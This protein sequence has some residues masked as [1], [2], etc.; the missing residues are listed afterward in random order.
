M[1]LLAN[2]KLRRKLF[3]A[4]VPVAAMVIF[5]GIYASVESEEIDT[6]YSRLIDHE[7]KAVD[8]VNEARS[9]NMRF[10]LYLYRLIV[11]TNPEAMQAINQGLDNTHDEYK[12]RMADAARLSPIFENQIGTASAHFDKMA[13]HAIPVREAALKNMNEKAAELIRTGV[14]AELEQAR[15]EAMAISADMQ[16]AVVQ[17][18]AELT[19]RTHRAVYITWF[20]I[21]MGILVTFVLAS[22]QL[23]R[24]LIQELLD[25]RDSIHAIAAGELDR[26]IFFTGGLLQ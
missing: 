18:S 9:L 5:A 1:H 12:A 6:W 2:L 11:E 24:G 4:L 19:F 15:Q 8:K 20:V 10:G 22:Y 23:Q 17:R 7:I 21:G 13:L 25:V 14:A 3:V 26:P 16:K